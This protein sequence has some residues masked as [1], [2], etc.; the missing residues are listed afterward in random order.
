MS[1]YQFAEKWEM[2]CKYLDLKQFC[3]PVLISYI[4]IKLTV[5]KIVQIVHA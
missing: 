5:T 2:L 1:A 4:Y 3:Q